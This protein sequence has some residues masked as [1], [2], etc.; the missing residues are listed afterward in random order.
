MANRLERAALRLGFRYQET[1]RANLLHR[2]P[3]LE[4]NIRGRFYRYKAQ[5]QI[6]EWQD[7]FIYR[8]PLV[9]E[10]VFPG[11]RLASASDSRVTMAE[12]TAEVRTML[13][14]VWSDVGRSTRSDIIP[15]L[16]PAGASH[17]CSQLA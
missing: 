10:G 15:K 5:Q 8:P 11:K 14:C 3:R 4:L 9:H 1:L 17:R 6:R 16:S 13:D 2:I 7:Q 12:K